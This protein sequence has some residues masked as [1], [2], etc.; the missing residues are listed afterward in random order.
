MG[1]EGAWVE[2]QRRR[3]NTNGGT[4]KITGRYSSHGVTTF[5]VTNVPEGVS[6]ERFRELKLNAVKIESV[7]VAKYNKGG[8]K[9]AVP[10][11][12]C[13][14]GVESSR[15][16]QV[17]STQPSIPK[18][19]KDYSLIG[20]TKDLITLD[21]IVDILESLGLNGGEIK[22]V[23]GLRVLI[24]FCSPSIAKKFLEKKVELNG[25]FK[26]LN[27]GMGKFTI[28]KELLL[29]KYTDF[30]YHYRTQSSLI[31]WGERFGR[32]LQ[33][34]SA[35]YNDS[36][37]LCKNLLI[38]TSSLSRI[39]ENLLID[40][41]GRRFNILVTEDA[42]DWLPSFLGKSSEKMN[43]QQQPIDGNLDS[44]G[45]AC[46]GKGRHDDEREEGEILE[47]YNVTAI[48]DKPLISITHCL[49]VPSLTPDLNLPPSRSIPLSRR[50]RKRSLNNQT[51][52]MDQ[53][54]E[55]NYS[56]VFHFGDQSHQL[57]PGLVMDSGHV[58]NDGDPIQEEVNKT[59][60]VGNLVG[61]DVNA[62]KEQIE[63]IIGGE[64]C[65]RLPI[66]QFW[67]NKQLE[68]DYVNAQGRSGGILSI[69]DPGVFTKM[70]VN[71]G[72]NFLHVFGSVVGIEESLNVV[73]V[74]APQDPST[75]RELWEVLL[76]LMGDHIGMWILMGDFNEVRYS[77]ER[78]NSDFDHRRA[79]VINDFIFRASLHEYRMGRLKY[80]HM[81]PDGTKF[82]KIDR[83]MVC[84]RFYHHW[85][86][87]RFMALP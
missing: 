13:I 52:R 82:S 74:Y 59:L 36:N 35:S 63:A 9:Q 72:D 42:E 44:G 32:I 87:A 12:R 67:K 51:H 61:I 78:L 45:R 4:R 39:N 41:G 50:R 71:K 53:V 48:P 5:Y 70:G 55:I 14:N 27:N 68:Y 85:P 34:S 43:N 7:N 84:D 80:T 69:W 33:G 30:Q 37:L 56:G 57:A 16:Y 22:Y 62:F 64:D 19:C 60:E 83:I 46:D 24:T 65:S 1:D 26:I 75:R 25:W 2:V 54:G 47:Q 86:G 11:A 76:N 6:E 31:W 21:G 8:I 23:G 17:T 28:L 20:Q 40:W 29:S 10:G 58:V 73:N 81:K 38:L 3:W 77:S 15:H 49:N 18:R 79:S 66:K